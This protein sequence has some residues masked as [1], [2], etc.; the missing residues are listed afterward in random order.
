M[1]RE[2]LETPDPRDIA[3]YP[4]VESEILRFADQDVMRHVN[5]VVIA[6]LFESGR[7]SFWRKL[8]LFPWPTD[9]GLMLARVAVDYMRQLHYPD[10]V[11]VASRVKRIGNASVS[12]RQGLFNGKGECCALAETVSAHAIYAEGRSTPI[13]PHLRHILESALATGGR[14]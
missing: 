1:S 11:R 7:I 8:G 2:P 3:T 14:A 4:H 9:R 12:L 6:S 5:N 13:P 10:T